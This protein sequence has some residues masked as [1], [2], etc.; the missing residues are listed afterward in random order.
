MT[1]VRFIDVLALFVY[2][3]RKFAGLT[4][5]E[6]AANMG[7][8]ERQIRAVERKQFVSRAALFRISA[9]VGLDAVLLEKGGDP[10]A[11]MAARHH[12]P[13]NRPLA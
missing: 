9:G 6:M 3:R 12:Q 2:A 1:G 10:N 11:I 13:R 4:Q 8:N 5:P 7:V